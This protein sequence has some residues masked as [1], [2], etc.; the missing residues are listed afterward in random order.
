MTLCWALVIPGFRYC[1]SLPWHASV[2]QLAHIPQCVPPFV[3]N[4]TRNLVNMGIMD[5][6]QWKTTTNILLCTPLWFKET[7]HTR[8]TFEIPFRW[9]A[10]MGCFLCLPSR[11]SSFHTLRGLED[12]HGS[13]VLRVEWCQ[14]QLF[15]R[16]TEIRFSRHLFNT[17]TQLLRKQALYK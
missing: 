17:S 14:L 9:N 15:L 13:F 12:V 11:F 4:S 10:K 2:L 5:V 16:I 7:P 3:E 6:V 8:C 1:S